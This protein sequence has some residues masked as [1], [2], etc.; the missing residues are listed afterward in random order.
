MPW[1]NAMQPC[2]GRTE[3]NVRKYEEQDRRLEKLDL[4]DFESC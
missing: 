1:G 4:S 3:A 2:Q